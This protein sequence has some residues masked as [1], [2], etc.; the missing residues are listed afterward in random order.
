MIEWWG[1]IINT[2]WQRRQRFTAINSGEW[3]AHEGS[4]GRALLGT[5]RICDDEGNE[6]P[7]GEAGTIFSSCRRRRTEF[8]YNDPQNI[9]PASSSRALVNAGR[10]RMKLMMKVF[11]T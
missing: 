1:Y 9:Q 5:I 10:C 4:V 8:Y 3:L 2:R 6:L 7:V 11:Y